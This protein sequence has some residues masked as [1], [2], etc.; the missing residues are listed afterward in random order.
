LSWA[1]PKQAPA[2]PPHLA[3]RLKLL[4]DSQRATLNVL[5]DFDA[6]R[7][8]YQNIQRATI[9]LLEDME[10]EKGRFA[11]THQATINLLEDFG[12]EK[13]R[14]QQIQRAT[15]NL[16][17]DMD[18][19]RAKLGQT[20]FALMNMVEDFEAERARAEQAKALLA[21]ANKE[22]EAFSYSVSHD[23]RAPLR[24]I[25]G[26]SE[27]VMED[28]ADRL[29]DAGTR[30]LRLIVDNAHGMGQLIDDLLAFS[31]L[32]RQEIT[33][34]QVDMAAMAREVFNEIAAQEPGRD[35]EFS[36]GRTPAAYA[37]HTLIRQVLL[38]L[39]ANAVKFTRPRK[40][41]RIEFGY[42]PNVNGGVYYVQDNGVGFDMKYAGKLF[43]VFQRLH[44]DTEFEGTGVGLA[45]VN[46]V[47][48][49]HGGR[50]WAEAQPEKGA[51]FYFTLPAERTER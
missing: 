12:A 18:D 2:E 6:E 48:A 25:S 51:T 4:E 39:L 21:S 37:D 7:R 38:N 44:S 26:F 31:R 10:A 8:K 41:A 35:I 17:Q 11:R 45:T 27:A 32:G 3:E 19:E 13:H 42:L 50:V 49:R 28:Y 5:E 46:R 20:Q 15:L 30:Y 33:A 22:L 40:K 14:Y 9:N 47:V 23:L 1:D 16:L 24:A 29:D 43:G 36:V 34:V